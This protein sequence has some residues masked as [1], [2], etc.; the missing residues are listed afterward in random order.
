MHSVGIYASLK[1]TVVHILN[2]NGESVTTKVIKPQNSGMQRLAKIKK[3]VL[4]TATNAENAHIF[5]S[6]PLWTAKHSV[7]SQS[8]IVGILQMALYESKIP[9]TPVP[10]TEIRRFITGG[11]IMSQMRFLEKVSKE[12]NR[13]FGSY[14]EATAFV[15]AQIGNVYLG[16][17]AEVPLFR[18]LVIGKLRG[19]P[20][21]EDG[22]E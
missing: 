6:L 14:A 11:A 20:R 7:M 19:H 3:D 8:E 4:A 15:L 21:N 10:Q 1:N 12:W 9:F 18:R 22:Q 17:E 16:N 13:K 5:I 2:E